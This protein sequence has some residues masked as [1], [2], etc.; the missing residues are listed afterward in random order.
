[1]LDETSPAAVGTAVVVHRKG[2]SRS[3]FLPAALFS[4]VEGIPL[5]ASF[6]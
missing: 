6:C 3:S 5:R 4:I 1:M 2:L